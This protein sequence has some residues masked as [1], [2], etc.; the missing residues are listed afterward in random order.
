VPPTTRN[1][2]CQRALRRPDVPIMWW[3]H[4]QFE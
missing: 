4:G 1:F 2:K 3:R